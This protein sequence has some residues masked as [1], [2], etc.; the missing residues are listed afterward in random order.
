MTIIRTDDLTPL[1]INMLV[2][3]SEGW[4][5]PTELFPFW[6]EPIVPRAPAYHH[7]APPDYCADDRLAGPIMDRELIETSLAAML[8]DKDGKVRSVRWSG[9]AFNG[10]RSYTAGSRLEAAMRAYVAKRYGDVILTT[11]K[12]WLLEAAAA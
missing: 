6:I 11:D 2:A 1:Q 10:P 9:M 12:P 3:V 4:L 8:A 7:N 5:T